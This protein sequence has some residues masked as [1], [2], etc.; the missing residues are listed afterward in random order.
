MHSLKDLPFWKR[1]RIH[2]SIQGHREVPIKVILSLTPLEKNLQ[3]YPSFL[4]VDKLERE[5]FDWCGTNAEEAAEYY[6]RTLAPPTPTRTMGGTN[7]P[8]EYVCETQDDDTIQF[9]VPYQAL[10]HRDDTPGVEAAIVVEDTPVIEGSGVV[11]AHIL[12]AVPTEIQLGFGKVIPRWDV[13]QSGRRL[14]Y[15]IAESTFPKDKEFDYAQYAAEEMK[16]A[17]TEWN[18]LGLGVEF[19]PVADENLANF[20]VVYAPQPTKSPF[21]CARSFFPNGKDLNTVKVFPYCYS[22]EMKA[23]MHNVFLH[24]LGHVL[25]STLR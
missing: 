21:T 2:P 6:R 22:T 20:E 8:M 15:Y 25:G 24:E 13:R 9:D 23:F 3:V 17:A 11:G 10:S 16:K 7:R 5:P 1:R 14:R 18:G 12:N 4:L 19:E